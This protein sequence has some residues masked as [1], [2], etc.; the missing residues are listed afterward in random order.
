MISTCR[1]IQTPRVTAYY[2]DRKRTCDRLRIRLREL[3]AVRFWK[4]YRRF[5]VQLHFAGRDGR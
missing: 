4:E 2:R 1:L 5:Y 3:A